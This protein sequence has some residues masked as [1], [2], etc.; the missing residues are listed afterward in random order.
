[1]AKK[2]S[3]LDRKTSKQDAK[4]AILTFLKSNGFTKAK[5]QYARPSQ[6]GYAAFPNYD[7]APQGAAFSVQAILRELVSEGIIEWEGDGKNQSGYWL[8]KE[9]GSDA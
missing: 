2:V 9:V 3:N 7:M 4:V 1:M 5:G 6:L 8:I